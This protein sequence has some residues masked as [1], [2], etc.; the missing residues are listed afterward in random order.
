MNFSKNKIVVLLLLLG[1]ILF[2]VAYS[3]LTFGKK[4][5]PVVEED[6]LPLP[7]MKD[8]PVQFTSK[9]AAVQQLKEERLPTFPELYEAS[10]FDPQKESLMEQ[11]VLDSLYLERTSRYA[12]RV[13]WRERPSLSD[14]EAGPTKEEQAAALAE[15]EQEHR[16]F[17]TTLPRPL[18]TAARQ[19]Q[20]ILYVRVD[21]TQTIRQNYRLRMRLA[22]PAVVG[23]VSFPINTLLYGFVSFRPQRALLRITHIGAQSVQ[24][25]AHDLADGNEGIYIENSVQQEATQEVTGGAINEVNVP[26]LPS[27]GGLKQLFRR[28][29]RQVKITIVDH[30]QLI[31]KPTS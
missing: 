21:G 23:G 25:S 12:G 5:T 27:V 13:D 19:G 2:I 22:K 24:Y 4:E 31:L 3:L 16:L 1:V 8:P 14:S 15:K 11:D 9:T 30:Y 17:F 29:N 6:W 28:R 18:D 26:G 10:F 20:E 7:K